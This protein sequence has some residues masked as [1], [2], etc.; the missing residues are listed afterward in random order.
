MSDKVFPNDDQSDSGR[1]DVLLGATKD[2]AELLHVNW[3]GHD[4]GRHIHHQ[5]DPIRVRSGV[6]L[7]ALDGFVVTVVDVRSLR[8][9]FP[10]LLI[11]NTC[12]LVWLGNNLVHL[13]VFCGFLSRLGRPRSSH[14]VV[15]RSGS[16]DQVHGNGGEQ[17]SATALHQQN[18]VVVGNLEKFPSQVNRIVVQFHVR[19]SPMGHLHHTHSARSLLDEFFLDLEQDFAG[20]LGRT[21]S[22][23]NHHYALDQPLLD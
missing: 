21:G 20:Q 4:V 8:V 23:I 11:G 14:H 6:E 2:N 1:A 3:S 17:S 13:S 22:K 15:S 9:Q 12:E 18:F 10:L 7:H 5:R 16:T 19:R